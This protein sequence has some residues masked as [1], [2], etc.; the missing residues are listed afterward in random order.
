[1]HSDDTDSD[2]DSDE[3]SVTGPGHSPPRETHNSSSDMLPGPSEC[4]LES[5]TPRSAEIRWSGQVGFHVF[6]GV[7][8]VKA[9][10]W[11]T[12]LVKSYIGSSFAQVSVTA[13]VKLSPF[14]RHVC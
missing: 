12:A 6:Q 7:E 8:E 4:G 3:A 14:Y 13:I 10:S 2:S 1:V 9:H 5:R 11:V